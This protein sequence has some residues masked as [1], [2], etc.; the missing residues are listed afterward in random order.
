M[1][2]K[3]VVIGLVVALAAALV[4]GA[5]YILLRS[6]AQTGLAYA[7]QI[8]RRAEAWPWPGGYRGGETECAYDQECAERR[9]WAIPGYSLVD[10]VSE[11]LDKSPGE[12][13]DELREGKSIADLVQEAGVDLQAVVEA[14][15]AQRQEVLN[16][17]VVAGRLSQEQ[18]DLML[19]QMQ[20]EVTARIQERSQSRFGPGCDDCPEFRHNLEW[21]Y[22]FGVQGRHGWPSR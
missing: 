4:G 7:A 3:I 14:F 16:Q 12:V 6:E 19:S 15:L 9:G 5:A 21:N 2:K 13:I 8:Q 11:L 17:A 22:R 18:A 10:V 1:L 20:G